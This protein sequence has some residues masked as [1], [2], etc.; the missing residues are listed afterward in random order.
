MAD[1]TLRDLLHW[2]RSLYFRPAAGQPVEA[3]MDRPISWAVM[4]RASS[5]I[6]PALRGGEIV[7][8]PPRVLEQV[9]ES[10]MVSRDQLV[11]MLAGQPIAALM[12]DETF[13]EGAVTGVPLLVSRSTF[14]HE[15]ESVLNRL[16][17]ERRADLYRLGSDLSRS[18]STATMI[19]AGLDTLLD[20][21]E[22]AGRRPLVLQSSEG[23]IV[24]SSRGADLTATIAADDCLRLAESRDRGQ[25]AVVEGRAR[26]RMW[27]ARVL[28]EGEQRRRGSR[29]AILSIACLAD[30]STEAERLILEQA[31]DAVSFVLR[32]ATEG[33][34]TV[35]DRL[36]RESLVSDLL[37]GRLLS[38]EAA[39]ARSRLLGLDPVAVSRVALFASQEPDLGGRVRSVL[40][41]ERGRAFAGVGDGEYA[42]I[43]TGSGRTSTDAADL[44]AAHRAMRAGDTSFVLALSDA[45]DGTANVRSA[46]EQV[47]VLARLA[48]I[49]AIEGTMLQAADVDQIG[50][51]ALFV[52]LGAGAGSEGTALRMR[53]DGFAEL[54]LGALEEHDRTR[55]SDL[56]ATLDAYLRLG[57][58]LA[59]AADLLGIHRNTLSYRLGRIADLSGR[60]LNDP[61][62]R[63]L[64][65][66]ALNAR[67]L[68]R[69]MGG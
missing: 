37:M 53:L 36:S 3:G 51:Y 30:S 1:I 6:L 29:G 69:A 41:E 56:V 20:A 46:L 21:A 66:V 14:A 59:Q 61:R 38:R 15:A 50:F 23:S 33:L 68:D 31:A 11:R 40:S 4:M 62:A 57:G 48:R 8:A 26:G 39:D 47:R 49:G 64:L 24:A 22:T 55:G 19:G 52:G 7:V 27:L 10:E 9:H 58:A 2:E 63:F 17:T 25:S 42:V 35:R 5:P 45:V 67:A 43:L 13:D 60:D 34:S 65:Q 44:A 18:L 12:V 16:I 28:S 32:Q 54:L